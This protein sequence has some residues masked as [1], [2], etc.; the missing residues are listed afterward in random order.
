MQRYERHHYV[1][2]VSRFIVSMH[3]KLEPKVQAILKRMDASAMK[4]SSDQS[5]SEVVAERKRFEELTDEEVVQER[6]R[7]FH[8]RIAEV[9]KELKRVEYNVQWCK[10]RRVDLVSLVRAAETRILEKQAELE[11]ARMF[12][13]PQM[14]SDVLENGLQRFYTKDL[15]LALEDEIEIEQIY[16][17]DTKAEIVKTED[18]FRVDTKHQAALHHRLEDRRSALARFD[19]DPEAFNRTQV[20]EKRSCAARIRDRVVYQCF[21]A[22]VQHCCESRE[23]K[24]KMKSAL[25][26]IVTCKLR[27]AMQTWC[28]VTRSLARQDASSG[29]LFGVG[30][31]NLVNASLGRGE[32]AFEALAALREVRQTDAKLQSLVWS[33]DLPQ[34]S[35]GVDL[36]VAKEEKYYPLWLE[37]EAKMD[38]QDYE[39]A[40]RLFQLIESTTSWT[41]R[42]HFHQV[43]QLHMRIGL[44]L[45]HLK[46]Y[47]QALV[48]FHR[49]LVIA[50]R[51]AGGL[52]QY[53][54]AAHLRV[55]DTHLALGSLQQS[56][57]NYEQALLCFE[58]IND[59]KG[60]LQCYRGLELAFTKLED[61]EQATQNK[62][63]ADEIG[64]ALQNKLNEASSRLKLLQQQL[65]G[66]GAESAKEIELERVKAIVPRL[67]R[68]RIKCQYKGREENKWV[69]GLEKLLSEKKNTLAQGEQDLKRALASD[70]TQVDSAVINGTNARYETDDFKRKLAKM[71]GTVKAAEE[72]IT[73]EILNSNVRVQNADDEIKELESELVVETGALM[74]HVLSKEPIRCFRFNATN[75]ALK[76]VIGLAS[77]GVSTCVA[78]AG[79]NGLLFD[80]LTGACLGQVV[81]DLDKSHLGDP[82]G[83]QAP[84]VSLFYVDNRIYTGS[85]DAALGVWD[86]KD[87]MIGGFSC[88]LNRLLRQF[89]S[90]IVS[91]HADTRWLACGSSDCDVFLFDA[92]TFVVLAR[93]VAAHEKSTT[94]ITVESFKGTF[95]TG[96]ADHR[97]KVWEVGDPISKSTQ[98]RCKVR[99]MHTLEAERR[100]DEYFNGHLHPVSC[101]RQTASEIVSADTGGRI[102]IW[103][104]DASERKLMRLCDIHKCAVTC[105]QFDAM[106]IVSGGADGN[107]C[108]TDF[109][110]GH[111]MQTLVGHKQN[112]LDLQFDRKRL[113]SMAADGKVRLW[114]WQT[115]MGVGSDRKKYHILGAGETLKS[116]SLK[117]RTS[118]DKLLEWNSLAD[119]SKM[120]LGQK[121]V[122]EVDTD[123]AASDELQTLDMAVS[124]QF[125][126]LAF[127]NLDF[128]A[129]SKAESED[130]QAQWAA[131]RLAQL[132]KEYF[133]PVTDDDEDDHGRE[134][135]GEEDGDTE[136][137]MNSDEDSVMAVDSDQDEDGESEENVE[138]NEAT[139]GSDK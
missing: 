5:T 36:D 112:V 54:G 2:L 57:K 89:D 138:A 81:G 113:V 98:A 20:D 61:T 107:I 92:N 50:S 43:C 35:G 26:R 55:A 25:E 38:V 39:G 79:M 99:L 41:N 71:M 123:G 47:D 23:V 32:L 80:I 108:V 14:D 86:V 126:K 83:H 119:S 45:F 29:G 75:E 59:V 19:M 96:G 88:V 95:T 118:I 63:L 101:V 109:A 74:R 84:I 56:V 66:I 116:I 9:E 10:D 85:M 62:S 82:I 90:A 42:M 64:F 87:E 24:R 33:K 135:K 114:Y 16:I 51:P 94:A 136:S 15:I 52:K 27:A 17:V 49:A 133:P 1:D 131:Q 124:T 37:A 137:D 132:A 40:S 120:Y 11:R 53:E 115:R 122:V 129:S 128:L 139:P 70:S 127:E 78:S 7:Q 117:Y 93:L 4:D 60:Q 77:H 30:S 73:K 44:A 65:V 18:L 6:R 31:S 106:K 13:G 46:R 68:E 102:V 121:L 110:T 3:P 67:R 72:H 97:V 76:N 21:S 58:G 130:I 8:F 34:H 91:I 100:G 111:L 134:Q 28:Q 125:G 48:R 12:R 105:L 69:V 103:N 22:L 104:L